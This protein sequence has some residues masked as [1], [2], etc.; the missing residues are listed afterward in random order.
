MPAQS[1][2]LTQALLNGPTLYS[3]SS[4]EQQ[5][6]GPTEPRIKHDA[7][8]HPFQVSALPLMRDKTLEMTPTPFKPQSLVSENSTLTPVLLSSGWPR[9]CTSP[10]VVTFN[11]SGG[12][13]AVL[14]L[15]EAQEKEATHRAGNT[16]VQISSATCR[17]CSLA[18]VSSLVNRNK[19]NIYVPD[20]VLLRLK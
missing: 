4:P 17:L 1:F 11:V 14:L 20:R 12:H 8:R 10:Q 7:Q 19:R 15:D 9:L 2:S 16:C 5:R 6:G 13:T 3:H 18:S